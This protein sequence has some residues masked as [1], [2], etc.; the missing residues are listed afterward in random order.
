MKTVRIL[1]VDDHALVRSGFRALLN[2]IENMEVIAVAKDGRQALEIIDETPIDLVLMDIAMPNLNGLDATSRIRKNYPEIKVI[3]L[4]MHAI[5]EY[6]L[7]A[8][9]AGAHGYLLKGAEISELGFAVNSVMSG[10]T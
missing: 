3:I 9:N 7:Q 2:N 6:V 8:L 5:E 4:S 10:E 1:L